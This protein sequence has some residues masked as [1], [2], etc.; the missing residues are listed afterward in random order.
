M[1]GKQYTVNRWG[2]DIPISCHSAHKNKMEPNGDSQGK[3]PMAPQSQSIKENGHLPFNIVSL[4]KKIS[5]SS[6]ELFSI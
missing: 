6:I 3:V 5:P 1:A 4:L 2:H